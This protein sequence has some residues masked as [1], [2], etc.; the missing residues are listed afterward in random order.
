[1]TKPV[2]QVAVVAVNSASRYATGSPLFEL[3]GRA[4][5]MLPITIAVKKLRRM[6]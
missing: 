1:M 3:M 6:T 2:T 4:S 5:K